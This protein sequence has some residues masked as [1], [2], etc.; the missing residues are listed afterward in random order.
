MFSALGRTVLLV[1]DQVEALDF[2]RDVLGFAVLHDSS[3]DGYRY[4]HVGVDGQAGTGLWFMP[5]PGG[6]ADRQA[7]RRAAVPRPLHRRPRRR[8]YPV[9]RTRHRY[10]GRTG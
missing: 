8:A 10:L 1:E 5:A 4:L 7:G 3:A 9:G 6:S 2:Y